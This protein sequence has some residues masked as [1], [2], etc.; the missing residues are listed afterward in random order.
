MVEEVREVSLDDGVAQ[1]YIKTWDGREIELEAVEYRITRETQ[2][3][4]QMGTPMPTYQTMGR[5]SVTGTLY[6]ENDRYWDIMSEADFDINIRRDD[7]EITLEYCRI[8]DSRMALAE[9]HYI[10]TFVSEYVK[11]EEAVKIEGLSNRQL[12]KHLLDKEY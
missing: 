6:I 9:E 4:F 3:F 11:H 10:C 12:V 1:M 2:P 7:V 8:T 5:R